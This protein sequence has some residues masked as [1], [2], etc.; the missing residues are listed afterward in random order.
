MRNGFGRFWSIAALAT[1]AVAA[2]GA[3]TRAHAVN[4]CTATCNS[5]CA[6]T[7]NVTCDNQDGIVLSGGADF[8][9]AGY[10]I[11]CTSNCPQS[12]VKISAGNSVVSGVVSGGSIGGPFTYGVN[13]QN[14]S[15]SEVVGLHIDS[16]VNGIY[17]CA[18][19]SQNV[20]LGSLANGSVW[21]TIANI[22]NSDYAL[23]NWIEGFHFGITAARTH[24]VDIQHNNIGVQQITSGGGANEVG[25]NALRSSGTPDVNVLNN[26]FF[27]T[28][29]LA[30]F[31]ISQTG[32][33]YIGNS[34][35]PDN[36]LCSSCS[37][38]RQPIAPV[39]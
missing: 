8:D 11:S 21:I 12:A 2:M 37:L 6:L 39:Y 4:S 28:A 5:N 36:A 10:S 7:Q 32:T 33:T 19:A 16:V 14:Q 25:I 3:G 26:F 27:G 22:A 24:D 29:T 30:D 18:K 34:C 23:D 13:C 17:Q 20:V 1:L 9:L 15:N 35:D 38:C 31:L